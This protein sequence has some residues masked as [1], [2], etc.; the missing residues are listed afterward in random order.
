[1]THLSKRIL[2]A[3]A[4]IVLTM[5]QV[6]RVQDR[7]TTI[8][9]GDYDGRIPVRELKTFLHTQGSEDELWIGRYERAA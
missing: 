7:G 9:S 1:M 8:P 2:Y 4:A 3:D 5:I 6:F